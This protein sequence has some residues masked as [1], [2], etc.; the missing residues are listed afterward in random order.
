MSVP[1]ALLASTI[2]YVIAMVTVPILG[3][4]LGLLLG[5][6]KLRACL[7]VLRVERASEA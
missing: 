6:S 3:G 2:T 5:Q 1:A 4:I 7:D